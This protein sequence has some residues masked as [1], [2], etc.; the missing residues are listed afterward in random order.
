MTE[1]IN[2]DA[3]VEIFGIDTETSDGKIARLT[4]ENEEL[5][6]RLKSVIK[7]RD[8][9]ARWHTDCFI[10]KDKLRNIVKSLIAYTDLA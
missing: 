4:K 7:E 10:E 2:K 8:Q 1:E 9:F 3:E 6:T 5:K